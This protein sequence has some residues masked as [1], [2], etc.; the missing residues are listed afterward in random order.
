[1]EKEEK[2]GFGNAEKADGYLA[3]LKSLERLVNE[4]RDLLFRNP[5]QR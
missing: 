5:R 1:M 4:G 2:E 3:L